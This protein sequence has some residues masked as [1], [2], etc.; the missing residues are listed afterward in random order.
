MSTWFSASLNC[1]PPTQS[2][3][4][5]LPGR[6]N[7]K[8]LSGAWQKGIFTKNTAAVPK[9]LWRLR[10]VFPHDSPSKWLFAITSVMWQLVLLDLSRGLVLLETLKPYMRYQLI[11]LTSA[12]FHWWSSITLFRLWHG[13]E[14][15][16]F[17][18]IV[19]KQKECVNRIFRCFDISVRLFG[20]ETLCSVFSSKQMVAGNSCYTTIIILETLFLF[21]LKNVIFKGAKNLAVAP[22]AKQVVH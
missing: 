18:V 9:A 12:A 22:E 17:R 6:R 2:N 13:L 5:L 16:I 1:T 15:V 20:L 14:Q 7:T 8:G 11:K 4:N 19:A 10:R 21:F 3:V